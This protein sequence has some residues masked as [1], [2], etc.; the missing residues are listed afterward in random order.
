MTTQGERAA[1]DWKDRDFAQSW[2]RDDSMRNLLDF[3]RRMATVIV[4]GD[5]PEPACIVDIA[6]GPGD[7]LAAFLGE[8]PAARGIWT[9]ASEVMLDL[10]RERLAPF[11]DRVEYH[12][13]DMTAITA[14]VVPT[15]ADVITT[16][17]AAH[18]LDRAGLADFY[19][20]AAAQ[21]APGGWLVNLDHIG[22]DDVW[23]KRL[24]AAR[25]RLV[26]APDGPKHHHN[27]P[28]PSVRDH[29]DGYAAA[30][31]TDVE[32][33]WRAFYTCLFMGRRAG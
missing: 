20:R 1:A 28:L 21:L 33:A 17:R 18:H 19:T 10:A 7:V 30:G 4:S 5:T 12:I 26:T 6:S 27:Y 16:S 24:R 2:A 23:D 31:I 25:K 15:G 9:D 8:F 14:D 11:G 22:P 29:L 13:A 3:P 32:V